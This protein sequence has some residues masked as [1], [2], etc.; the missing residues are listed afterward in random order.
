MVI[1]LVLQFPN[2]ALSCFVSDIEKNESFENEKDYILSRQIYLQ[3]LRINFFI[4]IFLV[5]NLYAAI[6]RNCSIFVLSS[7]T[8]EL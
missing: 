5:M 3:R 4:N 8:S 7:I 1:F 2:Y 6:L